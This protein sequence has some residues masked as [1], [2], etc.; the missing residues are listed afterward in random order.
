MKEENNHYVV[1]TAAIMR[2]DKFLIVRRSKKETAMAGLWGFPGGKLNLND[3]IHRP[4][5]TS[6]HW[7]HILDHLVMRECAE[8][9][10]IQIRNISYIKNLVFIRPD[11]IPTIVI[12]FAADYAGGGI[13]LGDEIIDFAWVDLAEARR[14]ELIEGLYDELVLAYH[15]KQEK[16]KKLQNQN[17]K[18]CMQFDAN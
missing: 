15:I 3:Y 8:E 10:G 11:N 17:A 4:K 2:G 9:V 12:S 16:P 6:Q 18:Y 7:H 1:A 13:K 5:N 14:Y